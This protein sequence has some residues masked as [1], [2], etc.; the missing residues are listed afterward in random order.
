MPGAADARLAR[1]VP[2]RLRHSRRGTHGAPQCLTHTLLEFPRRLPFAGSRGGRQ[3]RGG[4]MSCVGCASRGRAGSGAREGTPHLEGGVQ[5]HPGGH[6]PSGCQC[7][8][9]PADPTA[10]SAGSGPAA[11]PQGEPGWGET[12]S[13]APTDPLRSRG[14]SSFL[15]GKRFPV[16]RSISPFG[17]KPVPRTGR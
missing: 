2:A 7:G 1:S 16:R 4:M 15:V 11:A 12:R 10:A 3:G 13:A 17:P 14:V 6:Q 5:K 9:A 8:W